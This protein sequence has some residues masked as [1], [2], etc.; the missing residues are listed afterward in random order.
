MAMVYSVIGRKENAV[1]LNIALYVVE[2][3]LENENM[4]LIFSA[5]ASNSK[6]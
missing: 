6:M 5:I 2:L 1:G 4:L 3:N